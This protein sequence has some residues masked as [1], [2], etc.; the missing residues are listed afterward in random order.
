MLWLESLKPHSSCGLGRKARCPAVH[1]TSQIHGG[2]KSH[3]Q[4]DGTDEQCVILAFEHDIQVSIEPAENATDGP[5]LGQ[6]FQNLP[7]IQPYH[8][9]DAHAGCRIGDE[10]PHVFGQR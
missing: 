10:K 3:H 1:A 2:S 5:R 7:G 9:R 8:Q 6:A 4:P